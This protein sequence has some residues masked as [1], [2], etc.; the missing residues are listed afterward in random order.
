M[1]A[2]LNKPERWKADIA[3]SVDL[4]NSWFLNFAP[5]AYRAE[6]IKATEAVKSALDATDNLRDIEPSMLRQNPRTLVML[7]MATAPPIARDR[8]IGLAGVSKNLVERM[9]D[10]GRLP[11]KMS[12]LRVDAQLRKISDTIAL[13]ADKGIFTWLED[14]HEPTEIEALRAASV[15]A[16]RLCGAATNPIIRNAQEQRQLALIQQWLENRG[17]SQIRAG[18]GTTYLSMP[19]GTFSFRMN[20]RGVK[21]DGSDVNIPIDA[22]IMPKQAKA[23]DVPLLIEAK[24]A[25]DFT[26][27]NKRQKEEANKI[28]NLRRRHPDVRFV[29][30]LCGYFNARYLGYEASELIDWVW[31]HR[32]DDLAELG[33]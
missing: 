20:V 17:Y 24:S 18:T 21:S 22:V 19:L 5:E 6:R 9:E 1:P 3:Q 15:V 25:G 32:V 16:D 26:N 29:L 30:F 27:P 7:R 13:L 14:G 11:P 31:E 23:G 2:N 28:T 4:Y 8:L 33:L 12:S 10:E